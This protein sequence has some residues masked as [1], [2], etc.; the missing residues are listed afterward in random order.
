MPYVKPAATGSVSGVVGAGGNIGAVCWGFI[1]LFRGSMPPQ[2]C[3][4]IISFIVI[5]SALITPFVFI[6][7][8]PGLIF[9]PHLTP[10]QLASIDKAQQK[11]TKVPTTDQEAPA[12]IKVNA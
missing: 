8:Q 10:E 12:E 5:F 7:E 6:K 11:A 9:S 1:F 3:L 4:M 2:D